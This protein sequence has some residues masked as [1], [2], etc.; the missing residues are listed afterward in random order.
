[1]RLSSSPATIA[2]RQG[3]AGR[4][5][6]IGGGLAL[7]RPKQT[8]EALILACRR[9]D[10]VAWEALIARYQRLIYSI[11]RR[12]GLGE[13]Q[14]A[15][16]F[17]HVFATLLEHLDRIEQPERIGAWLAITARR[18]AWR[19]SRRDRA[20]RARVGDDDAADL[21]AALPDDDPLP[22]DVLLQ[23]E[24]QH[25]VR[26]AVAELDP[27]CRTLLTLLFYRDEPP[28]YADLAVA[29]GTKE[30]SIGPTRARCLQKLRRLLE[31]RA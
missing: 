22:E 24:E 21:A 8:D 18:E 2:A 11:P 17:Q 12:A 10:A 25:R 23:L 30:G 26:Q 6:T 5:T 14:A 15:D 3:R 31:Q 4:M 7:Q 13:E 28:P 16:V 9:G 27:R 20:W 1:L 29:L 19:V